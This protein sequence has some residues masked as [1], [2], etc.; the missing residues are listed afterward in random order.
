MK[1]RPSIESLIR[2]H[3]L[4]ELLGQLF[5]VGFH[6]TRFN[7]DLS[8]FLKKIRVGG[9]ILFKRNIQDPLQVAE[10]TRTLQERALE[11]SRIPLF[12]SID[13]EGGKVVRLG[14][15]FSQFPSA[16][17]VAAADHPEEEIRAFTG[18]TTKELKMVG[19][20]MNLCPVL[21]VNTRGPEGVMAS[22]SYG[23]D[24]QQVAH[25]GSQIIREFQE[26]GIMA[27]AK[28]FPGIGDTDL[29]SH[30]DLP[31]QLKDQKGL[32]DTELIP[33]KEAF[34]I[35]VAAT[36]ITHVQY[37]AWDLRLPASLS[38]QVITH[39]LRLALG[40]DGFVITDDLEMGAIEKH[41]E[42]EEASS[43]AFQAGADGL[44]ICHDPEK[45]ERAYHHLLRALKKGALPESLLKDSLRRN[46]SLKSL[47]LGNPFPAL[48]PEIQTYFR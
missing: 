34:R 44:L 30:Q 7:S 42:I 3:S 9:L 37:P 45:T 33:F 19:I 27:C 13:Q 20:N 14:P 47:Y 29:D 39:L 5:M 4:E 48:E 23:S 2:R 17:E 25:L 12:I 24:P 36:M 26:S 15:P 8:F 31:V 32:E 40:Y 10:L 43:L 16:S 28:H 11:H 38:R 41:F 18:T 1:A 6:G 21:D 46:L 22:R 35:P